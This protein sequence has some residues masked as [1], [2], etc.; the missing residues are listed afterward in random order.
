MPRLLPPP[1]S[2]QRI[3]KG[4]Q[5]QLNGEALGGQWEDNEPAI[6]GLDQVT[7]QHNLG[8]WCIRQGARIEQGL[9]EGFA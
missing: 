2:G 5:S 6:S 3:G 7:Q 8:V 4:G 1:D 9:A